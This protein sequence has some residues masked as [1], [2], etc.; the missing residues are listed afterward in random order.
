MQIVS[1]LL[2]RLFGMIAAATSQ[3]SKKPFV[4]NSTQFVNTAP[5]FILAIEIWHRDKLNYAPTIIWL[6]F[7]RYYRFFGGAFVVI[8]IQ[9]TQNNQIKNMRNASS[10]LIEI[11][12][13]F[14]L[15][16]VFDCC[17]FWTGYNITIFSIKLPHIYLIN[18]MYFRM[19]HALQMCCNSKYDK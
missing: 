5:C 7:C 6:L 15:Q 10:H 12:R 11:I 13:L 19:S 9:Y 16:K 3:A 14:F 4:A 2:S 17:R 18:S 8:Q 1:A